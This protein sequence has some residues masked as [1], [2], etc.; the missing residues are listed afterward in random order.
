MKRLFQ[1]REKKELFFI[2]ETFDGSS[3]VS[4]KAT[5]IYAKHGDLFDI[6]NATRFPFVPH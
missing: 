1:A 4:F 3:P 2:P 6:V 5:I